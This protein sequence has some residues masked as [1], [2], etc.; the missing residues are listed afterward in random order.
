MPLVHGGPKDKIYNKIIVRATGYFGDMDQ[1]WNF[2]EEFDANKEL[3][4]AELHTRILHKV[5]QEVW[6]DQLQEFLERDDAGHAEEWWDNNKGNFCDWDWGYPT[7]EDIDITYYDAM[8][9]PF[10][11][12]WEDED[13]Q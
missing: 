8:G 2:C 6:E 5:Q 13:D 7:I 11:M 12:I 1:D 10:C 9:V 3:M 4:S